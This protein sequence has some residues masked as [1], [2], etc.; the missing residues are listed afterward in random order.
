M[1]EKTCTDA[2]PVTSAIITSQYSA[3]E[4]SKIERVSG[5]QFAGYTQLDATAVPIFLRAD[6]TKA[7]KSELLARVRHGGE[8]HEAIYD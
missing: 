1:T 4:I 7:R 3:V 5:L 8:A 6:H 2:I